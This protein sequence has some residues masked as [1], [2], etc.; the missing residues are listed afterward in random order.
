MTPV[1]VCPQCN[2]SLDNSQICPKCGGGLLFSAAPSE[3]DLKK[4]S[5]HAPEKWQQSSE[6][7]MVIG[8]LVALG[9]CYGL[10]QMGMACLRG[11]GKEATSGEL[12]SLLG[13]ALFHGLQAVALLP[14]G[15]LAGAGHKRGALLGAGVGLFS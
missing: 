8:V 2:G 13:L 9:L 12:N 5:P 6:G 4:S 15:T 11:L 3:A 14:A 7:R 1:M 10:L